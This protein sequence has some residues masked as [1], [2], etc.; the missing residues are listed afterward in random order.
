MY[1]FVKL[2]SIFQVG[3]I[4]NTCMHVYTH[5]VFVLLR[6]HIICCIMRLNHT[7]ILTISL[8]VYF[9]AVLKYVRVSAQGKDSTH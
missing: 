2:I 1:K 8:T 6:I 9:S 4:S 3:S 5:I 7:Y